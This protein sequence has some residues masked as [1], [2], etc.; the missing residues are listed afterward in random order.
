MGG[1]QTMNIGI[2]HLDKFGYLGVFSSGVRNVNTNTP[3]APTWEERNALTLDD[4]DLKQ[5]LKLIWFATGKEDFV[6]RST[7]ATLELLRRHDFDVEY[8]ESTGGHVWKNWR[9]YLNLFAPLLFQ[10]SR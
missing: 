6:M 4:P 7:Q 2:P 10:D 8:H 5:G 1:G 3:S 9:E